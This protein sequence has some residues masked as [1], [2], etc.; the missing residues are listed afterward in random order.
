MA[1]PSIRWR[2]TVEEAGSEAREQGKLLLVDLFN[3][4]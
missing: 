2:P 4:G 3:P 1:A